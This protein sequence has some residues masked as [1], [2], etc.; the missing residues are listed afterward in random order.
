MEHTRVRTLRFGFVVRTSRKGRKKNWAS[1]RAVAP[2][3]N[4]EGIEL[5]RLSAF[6]CDPD[7][8]GLSFWATFSRPFGTNFGNGWF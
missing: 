2:T 1:A 3:R 4:V 8:P 7:F 6:A 5:G